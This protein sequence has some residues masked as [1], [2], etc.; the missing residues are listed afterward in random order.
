M[1]LHA[2]AVG[3]TSLITNTIA[4]EATSAQVCPNGIVVNIIAYEFPFCLAGQGLLE[5]LFLSRPTDTKLSAIQDP[6]SKWYGSECADVNST[7]GVAHSFFYTTDGNYGEFCEL[8]TYDQKA[9]KGVPTTQYLNVGFS[10]C[11]SSPKK[12]VKP[13][14]ASA[15][16]FS[17]DGMPSS[18]RWVGKR[19]KLAE[20]RKEIIRR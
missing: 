18:I 7:K 20:G 16:I 11:F 5:N 14:I 6:G 3:L 10:E 15:K 19:I 17:I 13:L 12:F 4:A 8:V 1:R 2:L 9:C